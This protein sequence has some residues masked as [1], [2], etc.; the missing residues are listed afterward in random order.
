MKQ[1]LNSIIKRI[2]SGQLV[3]YIDADWGQ[4][5]FY[6]PNAPV[7]F[8]AVLVDITNVQFSDIGMSKNA[9]PENRQQ[10]SGQISIRIADYKLGNTSAR[11]PQWQKDN[12]YKIWDIM[13]GL[14]KL[15]HGWRPLD[16]SGKLIRASLQRIKRNDGMQ[17][18][19]VTYSFGLHN[20]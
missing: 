3:K 10:A 18:Y 20:V 16:N 19:V 4:I 1:L 11:A 14:H 12:V 7:Q 8:P 17:E 13:D 9:I 2:D 5:D 6:N 15:L